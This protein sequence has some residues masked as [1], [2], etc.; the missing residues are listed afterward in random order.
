MR[1]GRRLTAD[2]HAT[3]LGRFEATWAD[4]V[5]LEVTARTVHVAAQLAERHVLRAY[6]ALHL[7]AAI[8]ADRGTVFATWDAD[9]HAAGLEEGLSVLPER[10]EPGA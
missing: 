10:I 9:L 8:E 5:V 4:T 6:D 7:G 3:A 1:A 2:E